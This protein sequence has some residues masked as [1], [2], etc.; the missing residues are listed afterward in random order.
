MTQ[1]SFLWTT[2]TSGD[3]SVEYTQGDW[4]YI[5]KVLG[6]AG[7]SEGI[8]PGYL[9]QL[10]PSSTGNN[11]ARIAP[12]GA[13]VDGRPYVNTENVDVVIPSAVGGGNTRIDRIVLRAD[14]TAHTVRVTRI[15]GVDAGSPT[16]PTITETSETLYDVII[17][18]V[19]V[20]EAGAITITDERE[21]IPLTRT[22]KIFIP[23]SIGRDLS[24]NTDLV[25]TLMTTGAYGNWIF[26]DT[27]YNVECISTMIVPDDYYS[28]G[29][30]E[31]LIWN[32]SAPI[33]AG[34]MRVQLSIKYCAIG[35]A[36]I[37]HAMDGTSAHN[38]DPANVLNAI[39]DYTLST[40]ISPGELA[41]L[42]FT[43]YGAEGGDDVNYSTYFVGFTFEYEALK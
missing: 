11:N 4:S 24:N 25:L 28:G 36:T 23:A 39:I 3:G 16:P 2:G 42:S 14:W 19:L 5:T 22:K 15:A 33:P 1:K 6:D 27:R 26:C 29:V 12:G 18:Q 20:T 21:D 31:C 30:V 32:D 17:C 41:F 37:P 7:K 40:A 38:V 9:S 10:S 43:R 13:I 35:S 34:N 8:C